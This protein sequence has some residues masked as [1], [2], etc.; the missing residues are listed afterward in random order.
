MYRT[1]LSVTPTNF[2]VESPSLKLEKPFSLPEKGVDEDDAKK[3]AVKSVVDCINSSQKSEF[4]NRWGVEGD[5]DCFV[6]EPELGA[7]L[8]VNAANG[9]L[10]NAGLCLHRTFG[11]PYI[12][13]SAVK[14]V[15][16]HAAWEDWDDTENDDKSA[17]EAKALAIAEVFGYPTNEKTLDAYLKPLIADETLSGGVC[18]YP[19]EPAEG[20]V[21]C[22][23][24]I[25]NVHHRDYYGEK[26]ESATDD[27]NPN[28]CYF[29]VIKAGQKFRFAMRRKRSLSDA[30]FKLAQKW[31]KTGLSLFG[32]GAKTSAGYG[33]F[34]IP[35][36][37]S[38]TVVDSEFLAG[39]ETKY[40]L[41]GKV[42]AEA[43]KKAYK[44]GEISVG[45]DKPKQRAVCEFMIRNRIK[46]GGRWQEEIDG[47]TKSFGGA[48]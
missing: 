39:L 18:F 32:I 7:R 46:I 43:F 12:P 17:K 8:I 21:R 28:L 25:L 10:E 42:K 4:T 44:K 48:V 5:A 22:E 38:D 27:E 40:V 45:D 23:V 47:W 30:D 14:G 19:A 20:D 41:D 6:I 24:D 29:P 16:R 2:S 34:D 15:A 13:G 31:L 11:Y 9:M 3:S 33:W 26:Q 35:E 1:R 37:C 36:D